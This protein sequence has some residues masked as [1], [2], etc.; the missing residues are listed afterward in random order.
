MRI[1]FA[2]V[3][4]SLAFFI[5]SS[6]SY[7]QPQSKAENKPATQDKRGT[8]ESPLIIQGEVTTKAAD[9]TEHDRQQEEEKIEIERSLAKY[10]GLTAA[11]TGVLVLVTGV[12]AFVTTKLWKSTS[13]LVNGAEDT[14]KRQL[15]AYVS[16]TPTGVASFA[17]GKI[18]T[19]DCVTKNHGQTPAFEIS[20]TVGIDSFENP[21]PSGF[22][23]PPAPLVVNTNS[24]LFPRSQMFSW[25]YCPRTLTAD[26]VENIAT[27]RWRLHLW[28]ET[29]YRD[30]FGV[31][32]ITQIRGSVGGRPFAESMRLAI[33]GK[34]G[35]AFRWVWGENHNKAT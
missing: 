31:R 32:H 18:V 4:C 33:E 13:E 30:A 26:E 14:A 6:N 15:R 22:Q 8:Q 20:H 5:S 35:P 9:K 21:L 16:V 2:I 17:V 7:P 29:S 19:L 12:L 25:F 24:T 23:Y 10:A 28:G 3:A 34:K 1:L 11:I 27:N